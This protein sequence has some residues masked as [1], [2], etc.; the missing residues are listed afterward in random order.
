[1]APVVIAKIFDDKPPDAV[2]DEIGRQTKTFSSPI[3]PNQESRQSEQKDCLK[4]L[5][6]NHLHGR[7]RRS[8]NIHGNTDPRI[9]D[10]AV[11]APRAEAAD[12]PEP[13]RQRHAG[14]RYIRK[15]REPPQVFVVLLFKQQMSAHEIDDQHTH[16]AADKP[17]IKGCSGLAVDDKSPLSA[18]S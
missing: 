6:G 12:T 10:A 4:Q 14:R 13:M 5:N 8:V 3:S 2:S 16:S 11:T 18:I 9:G 15:R 1:M 17:A 7:I